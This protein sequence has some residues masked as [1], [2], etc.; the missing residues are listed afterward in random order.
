MG[1]SRYWR[2]SREKMSELIEHGRVIQTQPGAVPQ[3]K[4]YLDEMPGV[5]AQ[6][7]WTDLQLLNNRDRETPRLPHAKTR[8]AARAHPVGLLQSRRRCPRPLL[9]LRH[10]RTCGR[11]TRPAVDRYRHHAPLHFADRE[12][13]QGCL[14]R[15]KFEVHG[16]PKDLDGARDLSNRDK[17]QFQWWAVSLVEAVPFGGTRRVR[18]AASTAT[19]FSAPARRPTRRPSSRSRVAALA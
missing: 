1:V 9:W 3:Q 7:I 4:R 5:P 15:I 19:S 2:Y 8:R 10:H 13:A 12:T 18:T 16:T 14:S 17:Y 11:K 6:D